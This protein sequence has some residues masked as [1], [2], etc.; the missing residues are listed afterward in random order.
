VDNQTSFLTLEISVFHYQILVIFID[1]MNQASSEQDS[2]TNPHGDYAM[3]NWLNED[4]AHLPT[5]CSPL[6]QKTNGKYKEGKE[7]RRPIGRDEFR[8]RDD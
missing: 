4:G 7:S 2:P 8:R 1:S 3:D 5:L 6:Q